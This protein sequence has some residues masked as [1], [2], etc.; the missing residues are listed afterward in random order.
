[1]TEGSVN[2]ACQSSGIRTRDSGRGQSSGYAPQVTLN[3]P[4]SVSTYGSALF[5]G[6]VFENRMPTVS[7]PG[8]LADV[9]KLVTLSRRDV[10]ERGVAWMFSGFVTG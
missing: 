7:E 1:M 2:E 5:A 4:C 6:S 10:A 3:C 8:R 9:S